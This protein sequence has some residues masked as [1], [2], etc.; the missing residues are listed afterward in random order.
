MMII[1]FINT[2]WPPFDYFR[3]FIKTKKVILL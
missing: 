1:N 2:L 3:K